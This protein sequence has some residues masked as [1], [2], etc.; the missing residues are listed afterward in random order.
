M[1]KLD[2]IAMG[3]FARNLHPVAC[4]EIRHLINKRI[5]G[6]RPVIVRGHLAVHHIPQVPVAID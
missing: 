2:N 4:Q 5:E 6:R 3:A 1:G